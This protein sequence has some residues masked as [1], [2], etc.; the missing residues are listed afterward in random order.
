MLWSLLGVAFCGP[1]FKST[2]RRLQYLRFWGEILIYTLLLFLAGTALTV[3]A[4]ALFKLIQVDIFSWYF[5]NVFVF[6]LLAIPLIATWLADNVTTHRI[7]LT[8]L[9]ARLFSPLLLL[10]TVVFLITMAIHQHNPLLDRDALMAFN[11]LLLVVLAITVFSL[12]DQN[13]ADHPRW[14]MLVNIALIAVTLLIDA[15]ALTAIASRLASLGFTPNRIAVLGAN[16]LVFIHLI[17]LLHGYWLAWRNPIH[18]AKLEQ[19]IAGYLPVYSVWT[20]G[21]TFGFPLWFGVF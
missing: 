12:S 3:F 10:V 19:W 20:I 7:R 4:F 17:G 1:A 15:I 6:G 18:K 9:L 16:L 11:G 14:L 5:R 8:W 13:S 2:E 21:V